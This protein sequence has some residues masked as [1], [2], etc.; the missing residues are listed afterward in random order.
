MHYTKAEHWP[1][2][3]RA[4]SQ[5]G[6]ATGKE[7]KAKDRGSPTPSPY[8]ALG[9]KS[10]VCENH[11]QTEREYSTVKAIVKAESQRKLDQ[12]LER[13]QTA[14]QLSRPICL[15]SM[16]VRPGSAVNTLSHDWTITAVPGDPVDS[17]PEENSER[18][19]EGKP[20]YASSSEFGNGYR[21]RDGRP[22]SAHDLLPQKNRPVFLQSYRHPA[23]T[24]ESSDYD[25]FFQQQSKNPYYFRDA[26]KDTTAQPKMKPSLSSKSSNAGSYESLKRQKLIVSY[27]RREMMREK[28]IVVP[29]G[30]IPAA[31]QVKGSNTTLYNH[32]RQP[33]GPHRP[34]S[35][36]SFGDT[37]LHSVRTGCDKETL[38]KKPTSAPQGRSSTPQSSAQN[39]TSKM[40][41][42]RSLY[43]DMGVVTEYRLKMASLTS[44]P[45]KGV[46][47]PQRPV[48][49]APTLREPY[50]GS[51]SSKNVI[52]PFK[53][54]QD[55]KLVGLVLVRPK[56]SKD[57]N[58]SVTMKAAASVNNHVGCGFETKKRLLKGTS[59]PI[60]SAKV[61]LDTRQP[62]TLRAPSA[63][64]SPSYIKGVKYGEVVEQK[65]TRPTKEGGG[66]PEKN[67]TR[68]VEGKT[69]LLSKSPR[70]LSLSVFLPRESNEDSLC[71]RAD[72]LPFET[73]KG[74]KGA[75]NDFTQAAD[76][77]KNSYQYHQSGKAFS[78][79]SLR[80]SNFGAPIVGSSGDK[81]NQ[82]HNSD[83]HCLL[84]GTGCISNGPT[85][86]PVPSQQD[87]LRVVHCELF[88]PDLC[89]DCQV[90]RDRADV[91][92]W[93]QAVHP[94]VGTGKK[95]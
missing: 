29:L 21:Q 2:Y 19:S 57:S 50:M 37:P 69:E 80:Y 61:P 40:R 14:A 41:S 47:L 68:G 11:R 83:G 62:R 22:I 89:Q 13:A 12:A 6:Q 59:T 94:D 58:N 3:K 51:Q 9:A 91:Q 44:Q 43:R 82:H 32:P 81:T 30:S 86:E 64:K 67:S 33:K 60:L 23:G 42:P 85:S 56:S 92:T 10:P 25:D 74:P 34:R 95:N 73:N 8:R 7:T 49:A 52:A 1:S 93:Q 88:G 5:T 16:Y 36:D 45:D 38:C 75:P 15:T 20:R 35:Q 54:G 26:V 63:S 65:L 28:S 46:V 76:Y 53:M 87:R 84:Q 78:S 71:H 27:L 39:T 24:W 90:Q 18:N 66:L 55:T 70:S 72:A 4:I 48:T 31:L 79:N 77:S 17:T